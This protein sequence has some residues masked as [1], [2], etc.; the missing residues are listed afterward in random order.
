M[1][2]IQAPKTKHLHPS[3]EGILLLYPSPGD[4]RKGI[5]GLKETEAYK[6]LQHYLEETDRKRDTLRLWRDRVDRF[7]SQHGARI[8][9]VA[10]I[11]GDRVILAVV[12]KSETYDFDLDAPI[13]EL[14]DDLWQ[15]GLKRMEVMNMPDIGDEALTAFGQSAPKGE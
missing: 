4:E 14:S 5:R 8:K 11:F 12:P 6:V 3:S 7:V 13:S 9:R 1:A 15:M 10:L 2:Q